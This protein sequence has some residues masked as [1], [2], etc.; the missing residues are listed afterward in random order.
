[1]YLTRMNQL[2]WQK[3]SCQVFISGIPVQTPLSESEVKRELRNIIREWG[4]LSSV[5]LIPIGRNVKTRCGI[6]KGY[7]LLYSVV[8]LFLILSIALCL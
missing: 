1:M 6:G 8:I 4:E 7:K 2:E 5:R 3:K